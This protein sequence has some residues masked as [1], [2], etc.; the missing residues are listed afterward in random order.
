MK[1]F[2]TELLAPAKDKETAIAAINAG[3]DAVYIGASCF[4]ARKNAGNTLEDIQ[5]IIEYA[6][7][8]YVKVFVTVNTILNDEELKEA[9]KLIN[10]L[11]KIKTG[12]GN[13]KGK[14]RC[15]FSSAC[16]RALFFLSDPKKHLQQSAEQLGAF[17]DDDLHTVPLFPA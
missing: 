6:H 17:P 4:G 3:A 13:R 11:Y 14:I 5:E 1:K 10:E 8:F 12:S 7:K 2:T 15:L 16:R 9:V